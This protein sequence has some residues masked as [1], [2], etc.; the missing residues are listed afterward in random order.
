MVNEIWASD[1]HG[2]NNG[3]GSK[4]R[5]DSRARQET[6]EDGRR[7]YRPK[8]CEYNYQDED[9]NPKTLNDKNHQASLQKF[10]QLILSK[11]D[12]K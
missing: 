6:R 1:L 12:T 9:N 8:C 5:V 10:R 4:F 11:Y 7:T 3:R 2:L